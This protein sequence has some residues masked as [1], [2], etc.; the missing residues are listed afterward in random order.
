MAGGWRQFFSHGRERVSFGG[1][2]TSVDDA[3]LLLPYIL[4]VLCLFCK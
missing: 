2:A 1:A 3:W 4:T